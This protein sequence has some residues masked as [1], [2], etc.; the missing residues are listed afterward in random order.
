MNSRNEAIQKAQKTREV[1]MLS[2]ELES[3]QA[4]V[5]AYTS[6]LR[7]LAAS[8]SEEL[9]TTSL[10]QFERDPAEVITSDTATITMTIDSMEERIERAVQFEMPSD[11]SEVTLGSV[12]M[13][14]YAPG[15][16]SPIFIIGTETPMGI[17]E[18]IAE[19]LPYDCETATLGSPLGE[20]LL[21]AKVGDSVDFMVGECKI[22][23][24]LVDIYIPTLK[25]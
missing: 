5:Q 19:M 4:S 9:R 25:N 3:L 22:T 15:D 1:P 7:D 18:H 23:V 2:H 8:F 14:E 21:G 10:A 17:P 13:V 20:A 24:R 16:Q 12:C 6:D 11:F